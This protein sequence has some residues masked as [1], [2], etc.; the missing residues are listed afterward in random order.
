MPS[1]FGVD[2]PQFREAP[3]PHCGAPLK[4]VPIL[5]GFPTQE[6]FEAAR[7]RELQLGGCM[8]WPEQPEFACSNCDEPI[9]IGLPEE[10]RERLLR[11]LEATP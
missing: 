5:Y 10:D 8:V 11:A 2:K 9:E 1:V 6:A 7:R 3:C 4:L